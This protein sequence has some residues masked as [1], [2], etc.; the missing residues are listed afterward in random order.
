MKKHN[1]FHTRGVPKE[2]LRVLLTAVADRCLAVANACNMAWACCEHTYAW[3]F[4][5]FLKACEACPEQATRYRERRV[6]KRPSPV[7]ECQNLL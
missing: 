6:Q 3:T 4:L 5:D 2:S 7:C 1:C